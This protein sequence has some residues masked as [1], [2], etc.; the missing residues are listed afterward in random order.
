M[1]DTL[2]EKILKELSQLNLSTQELSEKLDVPL[3]SVRA[4]LSQLRHMGLVEG[5][6]TEKRG[7]P[8][9]VTQEGRNYVKKRMENL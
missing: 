4:T 1:S 2:I 3:S 5:V 6:P 8:F 7:T 9:T